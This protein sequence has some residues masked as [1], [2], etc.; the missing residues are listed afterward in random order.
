MKKILFFLVFLVSCLSINAQRSKDLVYL[1]NGSII[2]GTVI[3]QNH[4]EDIIKI[5]TADG[6]LFV[7]KMSEVERIQKEE[8]SSQGFNGGN[9]LHRKFRAI[10][11]PAYV[12]GVEDSD[13]KEDRVGATVSMGYQFNPYIYLG[14]GVGGFYFLDSEVYSLPVFLNF[15]SDFINARITPFV[16][17]K[18]GYSPVEDVKGAY[19]SVSLGCRFRLGDSFALSVSTGAEIQSAEVSYSY[20][21][22]GYH[23]YYSEQTDIWGVFAKVGIDF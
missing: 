20:N 1:K 22:F 6:S 18:A 19:A 15:R 11:E 2:H 7:Y 5:R 13:Y 23:S 4:V 17:V 10:I 3:E 16:D 9:G 12:F 21:S 8:V 14:V